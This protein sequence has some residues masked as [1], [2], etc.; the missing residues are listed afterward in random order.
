M[1]NPVRL[2]NLRLRFLPLTAISL[3]LWIWVSDDPVDLALGGALVMAGLAL[4]GWGAG[5]LIKTRQLTTSGPYAHVRHPLYLGSLLC[6]TGFALMAGGVVGPAILVAS[7]LWFVLVYFP[8]KDRTEADRLEAVYSAD[9]VCYRAAVPALV[10]RLDAWSAPRDGGTSA[11]RWSGE[12]YSENNELGTAL[13]VSVGL[14]AMTA[15]AAFLM[16]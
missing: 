5:H 14:A 1:R 16:G 3:L 4:R 11:R 7:T 6:A 2:K 13:G 10:P 8:R 9:F 12:C 15:R